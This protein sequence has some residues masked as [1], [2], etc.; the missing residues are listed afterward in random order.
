MAKLL[1]VE[2]D[3]RLCEV[4]NEL[5]EYSDFDYDIV[6][7][8]E[9]ARNLLR[10][11][12]YEFAVTD[13]NFVDSKEG[14]IIALLNRHNVAPIIFTQEIDED[15][16][17]VYES[18]KIADY[19]LKEGEKSVLLVVEKLNQLKAN[20]DTTLLVVDN[21]IL[22]ANF[23]KQNL[24]MHKFKVLTAPNGEAA[25]ESLKNHP[26][27]QLLITEHRLKPMNGI[28]LTQKIRE[29]QDKKS[30][31]ILA[32]TTVSDA[33]TASLFLQYGVNDYLTKP[34]IRDELYAK[35]YENIV[36]Y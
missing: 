21:S 14:H 4:F 7:T 10:R 19:A 28:E 12:R 5:L 11:K 15:F 20:K 23:I 25:V 18:A 6:K 26:E 36:D 22:Y 2:S 16:L 29:T 9:D 34:F 17:E 13:L 35:V 30:L 3:V 31:P 1:V 27:I 33:E 24:V 32:L 8:Y